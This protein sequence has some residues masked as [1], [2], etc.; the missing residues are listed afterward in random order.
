QRSAP[1]AR[2]GP[3]A[4]RYRIA[5]AA[6]VVAV[7]AA[8]AIIHAMLGSSPAS[9]DD[10]SGGPAAA[11]RGLAA[12]WIAGQVSRTD[13]ISCDPVMCAALRAHGVPAADLLE[14]TSGQ[15]NPLHSVVIVA[16]SAIR[17]D[18]GSRLA[19]VDAPAVIASFGSAASSI[20]VRAIAAHG[21]AAYR[22]ALQADL[23]E[24]RESAASLLGSGRLTVSGTVRAQLRAGDVDA[25]LLVNLAWLAG[26]HPIDVVS[27]GDGGPGVSRTVSPYRAAEIAAAGGTDQGFATSVLSFLH[28]QHPPFAAARASPVKLAG[29]RTGVLIEFAA[30]SPMGV[31]S[32]SATGRPS[33]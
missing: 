14:L 25:R 5:G 10:R 4:R 11:A 8:G 20:Q 6:A 32:G 16:T 7:L 3:R 22:A 29:G 19:T 24:R 13:V 30:P 1:P 26:Q 33:H 18:F 15:G 31:F 17:A 12:A 2:P 9:P 28:S 21:A 23:T 27:F